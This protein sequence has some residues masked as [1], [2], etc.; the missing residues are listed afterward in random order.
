MHSRL[1]IVI[2]RKERKKRRQKTQRT[3]SIFLYGGEREQAVLVAARAARPTRSCSRRPALLRHPGAGGGGG[4]RGGRGVLVNE[5]GL[6]V[7][8]ACRGGGGGEA[9]LRSGLAE[10]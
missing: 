5:H 6:G 7:T 4:R 8:G 3:V 10:L 1:E 2:E 9:V